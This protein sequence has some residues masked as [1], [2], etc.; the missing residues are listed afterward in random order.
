M[1]RNLVWLCLKI[2][3]SYDHSL[4]RISE[5]RNGTWGVQPRNKE[6]MFSIDLLMDPNIPIVTLIGRAGS[7][8][9]LLALA[10]GLEQTLER[11]IYKKLV[12]LYNLLVKILVFYLAP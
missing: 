10:A 8:K 1:K 5:F 3:T 9:T 11:S 12:D 6:Q 2:I 7:G 4:R